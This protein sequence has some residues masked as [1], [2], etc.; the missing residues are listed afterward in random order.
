MGI[1]NLGSTTRFTEAAASAE[2]R[3]F[4]G[5]DRQRMPCR[6]LRTEDIRPA[7][8]ADLLRQPGECLG[9]VASQ[10]RLGPH[11]VS[12]PDQMR[13]TRWIVIGGQ[14][15]RALEGAEHANGVGRRAQRQPDLP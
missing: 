8:R 1:V 14:S 7:A 10:A 9:V 3:R 15:G 11:A 4:D 6:A 2:H 12:D 13:R 5:S